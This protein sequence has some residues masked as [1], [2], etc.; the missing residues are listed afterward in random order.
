M[1]QLD[2]LLMINPLLIIHFAVD[3]LFVLGCIGVGCWL[4][5]INGIDGLMDKILTPFPLGIG[6][7]S[8][9]F[10]ERAIA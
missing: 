7:L 1:T 4:E 6:S 10:L 9:V 5:G 2:A 3:G 8:I